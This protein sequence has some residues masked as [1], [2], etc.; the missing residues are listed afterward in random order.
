MSSD[1][2]NKDYLKSMDLEE[3]EFTIEQI[4]KINPIFIGTKTGINLDKAIRI[5]RKRRDQLKP[6][7]ENKKQ[8]DIRKFLKLKNKK[9]IIN[10]DEIS[11]SVSEIK[12]N[13]NYDNE[14]IF[15]FEES[16]EE[17]DDALLLNYYNYPTNR[18]AMLKCIRYFES[19]D[20]F[21]NL[22]KVNKNYQ[23]I[24][25]DL[26]YNPISDISLFKNLLF[27]HHYKRNEF[28]KNSAL[29]HIVWYDTNSLLSQTGTQLCGEIDYKK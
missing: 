23:D 20:D 28:I 19:N 4:K 7:N 22:M 10:C 2:I 18:Q 12:K 26:D 6:N 3:M 29:K 1:Y 21:I 16:M 15:S 8:L 5:I 17:D 13:N 11:L 27:Q 25:D 24:V 9:E 14:S